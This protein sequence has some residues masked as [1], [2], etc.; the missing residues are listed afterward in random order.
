[1]GQKEA[2]RQKRLAKQKQKRNVKRIQ[3]SRLNSND[4]TDR[5][6]QVERW[7]IIE[8][9]VPGPLWET[10]IG[11]CIIA[12]RVSGVE[13]AVGVFLVDTY[14][15]GVKDAFWKIVSEPEYR[16]LRTRIDGHGRLLNVTPEYLSKLVH[17]AADYAQE[18]GFSP[19]ADFRHARLLLGDI[20][21]SLCSE[22]FEFGKDGSPLYING[23]NESPEKA[24][25]IARRV[26]AAGGH[27]IMRVD[28]FGM[29]QMALS[30]ED[31]DDDDTE[32]DYDEEDD[33]ED[34]EEE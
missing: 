27:F 18:L 17:C 16:E 12:R 24:Q 11:Q 20:D 15:L 33:V 4:P 13:V 21:P 8:T 14:C 2:R 5:L 9:L 10:G 25:R 7:P 6:A 22:E 1:M 30:S 23:P 31:D 28:P 26:Q 3:I 29:D 34:D 19:H 32:D